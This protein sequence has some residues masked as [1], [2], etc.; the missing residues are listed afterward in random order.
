MG[1]ASDTFEN[2]ENIDINATR[3]GI[4]LGN[5]TNV[6]SGAGYSDND[7]LVNSVTINITSIDNGID[8]DDGNN[9][10]KARIVTL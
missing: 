9:T 6:T 3:Y 5:D 10:F 8:L 2:N 4:M 1:N 7:T